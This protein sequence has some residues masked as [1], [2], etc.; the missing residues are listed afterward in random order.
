MS[1]MTRVTGSRDVL[2]TFCRQKGTY[3][4]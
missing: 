4:W 2:L 1:D 3:T